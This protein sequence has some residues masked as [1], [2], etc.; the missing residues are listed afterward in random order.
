MRRLRLGL[1]AAASL[2]VAAALTAAPTRN[3]TDE[4]WE[5]N[6]DIYQEI[7]RH[8]FIQELQAGTLDR[9]AFAFYLVQDAHYLRDFAEALRA[10]AA[11]AP[12]R[13]WAEMLKAHAAQAE[14]EEVSLHDRILKAYGIPP[15]EQK[16]MEPA[17]EAYAYTRFLLAT[18]YARPFAESL[19]AVLPCYWI[20]WEVG[21]ELQKRGSK[22]PS[23]QQWIDAYASE[24]YGKTVNA[25]LAVMNEVAAAAPP[26]T[27]ARLREHYRRSSRYEWMFWDSA[28]HRRGWPPFT[29]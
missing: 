25:V 14:Q 10:I 21:K 26:E 4:L 19:A 23:Y 12:K 3:F 17:P 5:A 24:E 8:P 18:A 15:E 6:R 9:K 1:V 16:R 7:I 22:E 13:E 11:K 29:Q 20:Y 27:L 28:Y 2:T